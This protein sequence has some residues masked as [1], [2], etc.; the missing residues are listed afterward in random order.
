MNEDIQ[1]ALAEQRQAIVNALKAAQVMYGDAHHA[2]KSTYD[3]AIRIV[4]EVAQ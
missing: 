2:I 1:Y 4:M 3:H